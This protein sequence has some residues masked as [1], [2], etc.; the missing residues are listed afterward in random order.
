MSA[1]PIVALADIRVHAIA[2]ASPEKNQI[3][4][5]GCQH[6]TPVPRGITEISLVRV[7]IANQST[8]QK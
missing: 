1:A 8:A 4:A 5:R 7:G 3:R 6:G 2:Q